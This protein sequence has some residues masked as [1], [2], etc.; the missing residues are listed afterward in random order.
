MAATNTCSTES[1]SGSPLPTQSHRRQIVSSESSRS[2]SRSPVTQRNRRPAYSRISLDKKNVLIKCYEDGNTINKS[3]EI[4]GINQNSAKYII[5]QYNK[6]GGVLI[7]KKRGGKRSVKLN[8]VIL[9]KIQ[10]IVEENPCITLKNIREKISETEHVELSISS[11]RNGLKRLRITLKCTSL[12]VDRRNSLSTIEDRKIYALHFS[13]NAPQLRQKIIFIDES[14]FNCHLRRT[15][16]RSKINTPA[17]VI[18][19]TVRGRNVSLI[20]AINIQ[21]IVFHQ[22]IAHSTVNSNIFCDFL[23]RLFEKLENNNLQEVWLVLDNVSLHKTKQVRDLVGQ[24]RHT[25]VF[26]P[27]Y[28]PMMNPIEEVFSKVK[29]CARNMLADPENH[30]NL[31]DVIKESVATVTATDCNNYY[32]NMYM[33]LPPAAAGEPL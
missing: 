17:R 3:A 26:L 21:G 11:I 8:A 10:Q 31:I 7:E 32:M 15:K 24:T 4:A 30:E 13:R 20:A 29:L 12:H 18:V 23:R 16:A 1:S 28:S 6:N 14:G 25:L 19:P 22:T 27:P 33:K 9:N 2:R 5:K